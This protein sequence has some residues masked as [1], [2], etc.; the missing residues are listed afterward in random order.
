MNCLSLG[1][2]SC[3]FALTLANQIPALDDG[4][5]Q[6]MLWHLETDQKISVFQVHKAWNKVSFENSGFISMNYFMT[7]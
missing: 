6:H 1:H 2:V 5:A 3:L 7:L 4:T